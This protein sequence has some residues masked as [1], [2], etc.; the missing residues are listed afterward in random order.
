MIG[1]AF[2][3]REGGWFTVIPHSCCLLSAQCSG[4]L[5]QESQIILGWLRP[6]T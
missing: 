2:D 6:A 4:M 5:G 3:A 1:C